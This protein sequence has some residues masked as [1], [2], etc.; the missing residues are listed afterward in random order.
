MS[1]YNFLYRRELV[2]FFTSIGYEVT[3][4]QKY[5]VCDIHIDGL[6]IHMY[7][8]RHY[9][10]KYKKHRYLLVLPNNDCVIKCF[11]DIK[12]P[13]D[14]TEEKFDNIISKLIRMYNYYSELSKEENNE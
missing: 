13:L 6:T 8:N 12:Y 2:E 3:Q 14:L 10:E 1:N 11:L 5:D 7:M 9:Y 4:G